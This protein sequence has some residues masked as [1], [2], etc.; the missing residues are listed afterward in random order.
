M[1]QNEDPHIARTFAALGEATRLAMVQRLA[2]EGEL[3]AGTLSDGLG[4]SMPAVS[5]HLKVLR[6]AGLVT[7]RVQGQ[8]RIY[9]A[10]P[11]AL[12]RVSDWAARQR[13]YWDLSLDRL[14]A[15]MDAE[16]P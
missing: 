10:D 7:R 13:A 9:A 16:T 6:E 14:E 12:A 1:M 5:R 3:A 2:A 8:Q 15:A 4:L 11:D